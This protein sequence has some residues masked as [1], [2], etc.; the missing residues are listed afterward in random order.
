MGDRAIW[1]RRNINPPVDT[2]VSAADTLRVVTYGTHP[3]NTVNIKA[4]ILTIDG[5]LVYTSAVVPSGFFAVGAVTVVP[6]VEGSILSLVASCNAADVHPGQQYVQV[7]IARGQGALSTPNA[8][9]L[10]QGCCD[11]LN[12]LAWP[13]GIIQRSDDGRGYSRLLTSSAPVPGAEA[14]ASVPARLMERITSGFIFLTTDL[15]G[16]NRNV[17]FIVTDS[18]GNTLWAGSSLSD[19]PP[20]T[21]WL[22]G[23]TP[24]GSDHAVAGLVVGV[25]LPVD[26]RLP[27]LA[28][29][30]TSTINLAVGDVFG[31][32]KVNVD[33]W[34]MI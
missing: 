6:L 4:R 7:S 18:G 25:G 16:A 30:T 26:L 9:T 12:V 10:I 28:T 34:M 32:I 33:E 5:A 19:Q 2:Y 8:D 27:P 14:F 17:R 21:T 29:I 23:L 13:E 20:N 3:T 1:A 31:A 22:Y 15:G 11:T 24:G